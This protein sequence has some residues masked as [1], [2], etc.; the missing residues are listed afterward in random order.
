MKKLALGFFFFA[1]LTL[2]AQLS[3]IGYFNK[4]GK[5]FVHSKLEKAIATVDDGLK[6]FPTDAA[7]NALRKKLEEEKKK[8]DQNKD[9][10]DQEKKEQDQKD[11]AKKDQ[12]KKEQQKPQPLKMTA[13]QIKQL[14]ETMN[15]EEKKTQKKV[16]AQKIKGQQKKSQ[17]KDW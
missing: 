2:Q 12:E 8:K 6:K 4:G 15:N 10:K 11:Q 1:S 3:A 17:E 5:E 9:K 16:N 14:L 7:L 13:E